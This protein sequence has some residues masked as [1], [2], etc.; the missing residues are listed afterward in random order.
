MVLP[1]SVEL[2]MRRT[3]LWYHS[4]PP[5]EFVASL[6]SMVVN[7]TVDAG[8]GLTEVE[9]AA[10]AVGGVVPRDDAA[11]DVHAVAVGVAHHHAAT[12]VRGVAGDGGVRDA[13]RGRDVIR[14]D[15]AAVVA[16]A[17]L[18]VMVL[19]VIENPAK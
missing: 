6:P 10:V 9:A 1:D 4:M 16:D 8:V 14:E 18:P 12:L 19:P 11:D 7:A 5:P 3:S 17:V 15:P 13:G 2:R